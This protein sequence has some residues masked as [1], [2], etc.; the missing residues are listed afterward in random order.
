MKAYNACAAIIGKIR[1]SRNLKV[2]NGDGGDGKEGHEGGIGF[3]TAFYEYS[4]ANEAQIGSQMN[5]I[6]SMCINI[7]RCLPEIERAVKHVFSDSFEAEIRQPDLLIVLVYEHIVR[8][9]KLKIGGLLSRMV[10]D[11]SAE[12]NKLLAKLKE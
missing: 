1:Q 7:Y 3:K 6:Y 4:E 12:L 9:E 2:S 11:N 8:G 5:R 10:K